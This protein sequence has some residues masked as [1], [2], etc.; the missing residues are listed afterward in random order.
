MKRSSPTKNQK[1][2]VSANKLKT[3][4]PRRVGVRL[5]L[6]FGDDC[7][8]GLG[9]YRLLKAIAQHDSLAQAAK[10]V[11]LSYRAA[12]KWVEKLNELA[13]QPLV[14]KQPGGQSGGRTSLTAAGMMALR[15]FELAQ[16]KIEAAIAAAEKQIAATYKSGK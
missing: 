15:A 10:S 7:T 11:G 14:I 13:R 6:D 16:K 4:P 5:W 2:K 8:L 9:R 1:A 3:W 12:W